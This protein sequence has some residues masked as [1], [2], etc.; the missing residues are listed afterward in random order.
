MFFFLRDGETWWSSLMTRVS[1]TRRSRVDQVGRQSAGI[2][3]GTMIGTAIVSFAGGVLQWFTMLILGLPLAFPIGVLM[4]LFGFVPYVGGLVATSL[5]FLVAVSVGS[6][7]DV[8]LMFIFTI[9]F[10]IVQGNVVQP[11]VYGKTV[12]IHPAVVL[13]AIPAGGAIGGL[14]GMVIV[15]PIISIIFHSWRTVL[16]LFDPEESQSVAATAVPAPDAPACRQ[17]SL[18]RPRPRRAQSRKASV[19][20]DGSDESR[21]PAGSERQTYPAPTEV[22]RCSRTSPRSPASRRTTSRPRSAS[23]ARRSASTSA[24]TTGC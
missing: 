10:N 18:P 24:T 12:N 4:F 5:G 19:A 1:T 20:G 3:R 8:I 9:V 17:A 11:L 13:M 7:A 23:M 2:L 16:H 21:P 15:V 6:Q 22:S 14:L